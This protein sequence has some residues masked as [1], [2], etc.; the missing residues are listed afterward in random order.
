V[1]GQ[2]QTPRRRLLGVALVALTVLAVPAVGGADPSTSAHALRQENA[3]LAAKSRAAVLSL[4]SLDSQLETARTR[5]AHLQARAQ[6]L[7][8]ERAS[9]ARQLRVARAGVRISQR[10]LASRLRLLYE[11]GDV[12][13]IEVLLGAKSLDDALTGL[14][15]LD[16]V[17]SQDEEVLRQ[18]H[19]A[20]RRLGTAST[21]LAGRARALETATRSA[22][23][24]A[25]SL[26]RTRSE[27]TAYIAQIAQE[28]QLNATQ[29]SRLEAQARAATARS[30]QLASA[31]PAA[32]APDLASAAVAPAAAATPAVAPGAGGGTITVTAT[33]YALSGTTA[34]GLPVGWGIA[35]V[36]PRVIP[37]G[38]HMTIPG[39]GEAVAADTG[40]A[41]VGATVDL[42]FPSV[43]EA[44]A[45]GRRTVTISLH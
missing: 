4:Y 2:A 8:R 14:D 24:T 22:A 19:T 29:I 33:G 21:T 32:P 11:Q 15:N 20:K 10:H 27:R 40:G 39:Y 45:W 1:L 28:R 9:L 7:R 38:T 18:L 26:E 13:A 17:A 5:L 36:D 41:V 34:T 35:A 23:A 42:W 16:R 31:P 37:L 3:D 25:A 12:S 30:E 43:A 6:E 44:Q